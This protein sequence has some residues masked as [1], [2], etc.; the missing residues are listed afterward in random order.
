MRATLLLVFVM[1]SATVAAEPEKLA[2]E[3]E[4]EVKPFLERY[5]ADCHSGD[6]ARSRLLV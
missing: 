1:C 6:E 4:L 5:C 2:K 3:F